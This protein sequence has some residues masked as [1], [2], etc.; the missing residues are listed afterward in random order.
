MKRFAQKITAIDYSYLEDPD[1][2]DLKERATFAIQSY[3]A[4]AVIVDAMIKFLAAVFTL[5]GIGG[6]ISQFNY[7]FLLVIFVLSTLSLA[8]SYRIVI[9]TQKSTQMV[10][11][12]NRKYN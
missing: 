1:I 9:E 3:G 8:F 5:I 4:L 12:V 6:I 7:L 10:I 2:L 11:P